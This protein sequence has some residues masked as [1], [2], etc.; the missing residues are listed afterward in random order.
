[1]HLTMLVI[2]LWA[3]VV[4]LGLALYASFKSN[5]VRLLNGM[6]LTL[7]LIVLAIAITGTLYQFHAGTI[8]FIWIGF[9]ALIGFILSLF[10]V[11]L[12]I[13][14]LWNAWVVWHKESHNLG[15]LL[16]LILGLVIIIMP[17]F[18][19]LIHHYLPNWLAQ[20]IQNIYGS[21][22]M[23]LVFWMISFMMS[24]V[25]YK[26]FKPKYD[27]SY[28]IVL[29]AGLLDSDKISPLLKS[30]VN[31]A[32]NFANKQ[33]EKAGYRPSLVMSGGQGPDEKIPEGVAMRDYA[34]SEGFPAD[35][36]YVEDQSQTTYQNMLY[37]KRVIEQQLDVNEQNGLFATSDYHVF[38]AAGYARA[39]GLNIDGIGAKTSRYFLYNAYL[40]EYVALL[41]NHKIFHAICLAAIV[42][43]NIG[44]SSALGYST[45]W[46]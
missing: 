20:G 32:I 28:I 42:L 37:S 46:H 23:Y 19:R 29:G 16:T 21:V 13:I 15:N 22:V 45:N 27:Q 10:S 2:G 24:L 7:L 3:V 14:L 44:L 5:K 17:V 9:L 18:M 41:S 31:A 30:R 6:L 34:L 43:I 8:L 26:L 39:V 38:R 35:Q 40:R 36:V 4:C 11:C 33:F 25:L 12:W 1:M